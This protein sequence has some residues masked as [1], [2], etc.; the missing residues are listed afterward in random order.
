[1]MTPVY[2]ALRNLPF[3]L[4]LSLSSGKMNGGMLHAYL[5]VKQ[6]GFSVRQ[7]ALQHGVSK[8]TLHLRLSCPIPGKAGKPTLLTDFE[9]GVLAALAQGHEMFGIALG[10]DA[11]L[12]IV[13]KYTDNKRKF[14]HYFRVLFVPYLQARCRDSARLLKTARKR[15]RSPDP[16]S[17]KHAKKYTQSAVSPIIAPTDVP[18]LILPVIPLATALLNCPIIIKIARRGNKHVIV[19][20]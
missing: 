12:G 15:R 8:S 11:F 6:K 19:R 7:A 17:R 20:T 14:L 18:A 10:P 1:M 2:P 5:D 13:R 4:I 16:A 9:E 3:L